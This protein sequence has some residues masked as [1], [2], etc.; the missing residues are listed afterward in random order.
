M[1][2]ELPALPYS[3]TALEPYIDEETLITH[4]SK[5]H[6]K[7]VAT[8]NSLIANTEMDTLSLE[9]LVKKSSGPLFNNA[10][11]VWNHTFYWNSLSPS[12]GGLPTGY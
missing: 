6:A 10:A 3:Y 12:G 7:Y 2:I 4:H 1:P 11:Q 9:E 5:H 8:A